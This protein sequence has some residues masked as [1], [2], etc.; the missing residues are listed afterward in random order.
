L[1]RSSGT[2]VFIFLYDISNSL[3]TARAEHA[4]PPRLAAIHVATARPSG[5]DQSPAA[6]APTRADITDALIQPPACELKL[7]AVA[8]E[9]IPP[10]RYRVVG[11]RAAALVR[12]L[13]EGRDARVLGRLHRGLCWAQLLVVGELGC[14]PL[15]R[16]GGEFLVNLPSGRHGHRSIIITTNLASSEG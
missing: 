15:H 11:P 14:V 3:N 2:L 10:G 4:V 9:Y 1:K 6:G 7:P 16:T 13:V 8:R 12:K 5:Y